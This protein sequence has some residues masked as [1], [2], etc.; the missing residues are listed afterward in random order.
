M[1]TEAV[2]PSGRARAPTRG[3]PV[4]PTRSPLPAGRPRAS[5]T[6]TWSACLR[7]TPRVDSGS[8]GR[9]VERQ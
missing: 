8:F 6:H 1:V 7:M 9:R 3:L 4:S 2:F 5:T